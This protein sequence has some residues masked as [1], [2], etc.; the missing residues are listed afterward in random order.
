MKRI[1]KVERKNREDVHVLIERELLDILRAHGF[2]I[3]D[4]INIALEKYLRERNLLH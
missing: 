4:V 2:N 1:L 3:S